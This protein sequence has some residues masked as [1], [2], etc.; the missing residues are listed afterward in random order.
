M[1]FRLSDSRCEEIKEVVTSLLEKL[2]ISS[3]PIHGFEIASKLK[4]IV[5]PYSSFPKEKLPILL[6]ES[7]DGFSVKYNNQWYI[8][9]N[10]KL[11]GKGTRD[12]YRITGLAAFFRDNNCKEGDSLKIQSTEVDDCF[13]I[14]VIRVTNIEDV[15]SK[16]LTIRA[17]WAW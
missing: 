7:E 14:E 10:N 16:D 6:K 5:I 13:E 4:I 1:A 11:H 15:I 9:Y 2:D 12:E 8:Y 3:I 17:D